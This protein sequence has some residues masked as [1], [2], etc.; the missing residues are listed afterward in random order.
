MPEWKI[1]RIKDHVF[2]NEH[3]L[4]AG[5]RFDAD[6]EIADTWYRSNGTYNQNDIDLLNL[7]YFESKFE[8]FIRLIIE[9]HIIKQK[10]Q[11]EYGIHIR[12]IINGSICENDKK[13]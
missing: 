10:N 8:S 13:V 12:R 5:V 11:E 1:S 4:D 7:E 2:S 6:R 3:I 9:R